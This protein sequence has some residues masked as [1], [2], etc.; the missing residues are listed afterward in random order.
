MNASYQAHSNSIHWTWR[1]IGERQEVWEKA[2]WENMGR[3]EGG[4]GEQ[5]RSYFAN[6]YEVLKNKD[7]RGIE[8]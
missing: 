4:N 5:I 3:I 2:Y 7:S 8:I 6:T 1:A